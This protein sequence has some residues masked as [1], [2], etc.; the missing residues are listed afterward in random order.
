MNREV[1]WQSTRSP[2]TYLITVQ[3]TEAQPPHVRHYG[4]I[5]SID[6]SKNGK[7]R[8]VLTVSVTDQ[9]T[10][11]SILNQLWDKGS[12]LISICIEAYTPGTHTCSR[13]F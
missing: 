11:R 9:D 13:Y 10:L 1:Q 5:V 8:T 2:Q 6:T 4:C 3:G 12:I 7:Q